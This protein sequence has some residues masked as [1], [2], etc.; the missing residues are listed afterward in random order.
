MASTVMGCFQG[1]VEPEFY[2][3]GEAWEMPEQLQ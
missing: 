3:K 1:V 2:N